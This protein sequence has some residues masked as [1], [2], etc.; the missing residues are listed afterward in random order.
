[1]QRPALC[2]AQIVGA[3]AAEL[4]G[5]VLLLVAS[6]GM[7][8]PTVPP[9]RNGFRKPDAADVQTVKPEVLQG[10]GAHMAAEEA[11]DQFVQGSSKVPALLRE[12]LNGANRAAGSPLKARG[13]LSGVPN[14]VRA[15]QVRAGEGGG[16]L[17]HGG[18]RGGEGGG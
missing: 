15:M 13:S 1:M 8:M 18:G 7:Q 9:L 6:L 16:R 2:P 3:M 10:M 5:D 4:S 14:W 12:S 11:Y 17:I